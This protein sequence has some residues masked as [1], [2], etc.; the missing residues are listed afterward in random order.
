MQKH[1]V[2]FPHKEFQS[3]L[4]P[5]EIAI[6]ES[7]D[8]PQKVQAFLTQEIRYNF[9]EDGE[10]TQSPLEVLRTGTAHCFEGALF[11]AAVLWYHGRPPTLVLIEA[12]EDYDHNLVIYWENGKV[13][14]VAQS[15]HPELMGKPATFD[16]TR[17]LALSY[18]PDYYSD[19]TGNRNDL[20]MRGF[21]EPIDLRKFGG[22][23]I[24]GKG[25]WNLYDH[26]LDG[27]RLERL[28]P[29]NEEDRYYSYP[30]ENA[31]E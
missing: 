24:L 22:A 26:Y 2:L 28:F 5:E 6:I 7:L 30:G 4:K 18:Y 29:K 16:T 15:R 8:S 17:D 23:W 13:G 20:T 10:T 27:V 14:S 3:A 31:E 9:E 1:A 25:I 19:W 21:S 12:P 11:A